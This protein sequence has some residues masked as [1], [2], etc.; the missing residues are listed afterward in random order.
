MMWPFVALGLQ[1]AAT[2]PPIERAV[3]DG[4]ARGVFPGAVVVVGRPYNT[5]DSGAC[6]GLPEKL[7]KF[8]VHAIPMDMLPLERVTLPAKY[9]N[10]FWRSGQDILRAARIIADDP[11]LH[12]VYLTNFACGPD[13]F[14]MSYFRD[15]MGPKPFLEL[16]VDEHT[17]D[18]GV[19][20][21]IEAFLDSVNLRNVEAHA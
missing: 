18:A 14:I 20:T 6:L 11:R 15:T 8:G 12:A 4:I 3:R 5:N 17:A 16:E 2:L 19:L 10:M 9:D 13:S 7:R 1:V 21:R